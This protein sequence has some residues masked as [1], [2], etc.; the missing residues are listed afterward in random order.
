[1]K[2]RERE[3][4]LN[5]SDHDLKYQG[6]VAAAGRAPPRKQKLERANVLGGVGQRLLTAD[7]RITKVPQ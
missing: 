6:A 3:P 4:K 7:T 5:G 2:E 1:M